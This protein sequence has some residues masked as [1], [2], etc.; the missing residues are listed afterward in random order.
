MIKIVLS[1]RMIGLSCV[2]GNLIAVCWHSEVEGDWL[3]VGEV[4]F[5]GGVA[6]N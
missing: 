6:L 3:C 1:P 4:V 5:W 2:C